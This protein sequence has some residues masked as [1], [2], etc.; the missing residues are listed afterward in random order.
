MVEE[1][2]DAASIVAAR[3]AQISA[4]SQEKYNELEASNL[5]KLRDL[6][7]VSAVNVSRKAG[8]NQT[9]VQ[10][11]LTCGK[12][13]LLQCATAYAKKQPKQHCSRA[14]PSVAQAAEVLMVRLLSDHGSC[15]EHL[16]QEST[17]GSSSQ[18]RVQH[19][20]AFAHMSQVRR[21]E[22]DADAAKLREG[23][24]HRQ[25]EQARQQVEQACC[26][27]LQAVQEREA[28]EAAL[29][30]LRAKRQKTVADSAEDEAAE[31]ATDDT[32]TW[33]SW[34]LA[35]WRKHE[36]EVQVRRAVVI[37][38][39]NTDESLPPRGDEERGWRKHWRRGLIGSIQDWAEGRK[40]RVVFMLAE[41]ARYFKVEREVSACTHS[42]TFGI[43]AA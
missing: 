28:A 32:P 20:D 23:D 17:G 36:S 37:D 18:E 21:L 42:V 8:L 7:N 3:C 4:M 2:E 29:R 15:I 39:A 41:M 31:A 13:S 27:E 38:I 10:V 26:A 5:Q 40:H 33:K 34:S 19:I 25:V 12:H 1:P 43:A 11:T 6:P 9:Y 14:I 30:E 22:A 35:R 24:A 16:Q